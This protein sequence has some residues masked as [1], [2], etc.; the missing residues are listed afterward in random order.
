MHI[1]WGKTLDDFENQ[2]FSSYAHIYPNTDFRIKV[3][4]QAISWANV[5]PNL[6]HYML[7]LGQNE[8][9]GVMLH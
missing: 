5:D 1:H 6:C 2:H 4:P 8:L 7:W 3:I 9:I